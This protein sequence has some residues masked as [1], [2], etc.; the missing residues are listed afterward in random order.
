MLSP[1]PCAHCRLCP[2]LVP[3]ATAP[4]EDFPDLELGGEAFEGGAED[5]WRPAAGSLDELDEDDDGPAATWVTFEQ[6]QAAL[7]ALEAAE[8]G[9]PGSG[10]YASD[11]EEGEG[12]AA[13]VAGKRLPAEV[14]CFDTAR[15]YVKGGD[16][17]RGCVAFRREKYVPKGGPSGGNG[18]HGGSVYL[19]VDPSL[20]SLMAFRR[21]VHFRCA[22]C[23]GCRRGQARAEGELTP[24]PRA[25]GASAASARPTPAHRRA[26]PGVPGQ[27]SDMHG[28][29]GKDLL[30]KVPPGTIVRA[31]G[32]AEGDPPLYELLRPGARVRVASGGRGGRGNLAFKSARNNAPALAEFGE[33]VRQ[34]RGGTRTRCLPGARA[35]VAAALLPAHACSIH[36]IPACRAHTAG[37]RGVD[38]P[39]AEAGGRC[40]H[41]RLPQRRQEH[42][43]QV[44]CAGGPA[45]LLLEGLAPHRLLA[46]ASC[47]LPPAISPCNTPSGHHPLQRGVCRQAQDCQLPLH[48]A[49]PQPGRVQPGLPHHRVCRRAGAAGGR[50]RGRGAGP[51]VPAALPALPRAGAR[52]RRHQPRPHGRLP[53]HPP[54]ARPVQPAAGRQAAGA[55]LVRRRGG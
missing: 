24:Q 45:V 19:E 42:A 12:G 55:V 10:A 38:R 44:R 48:H 13:R 50:A 5:E 46:G 4:P 52:G 21:Q 32:A 27:G 26:E 7:A 3:Q 37:R 49:G 17:G 22:S 54:G 41:H 1:L 31:R 29:A 35:H 34:L 16:G 28:A 30:V 14:R 20:N 53:R 6:E 11:D 33:K 25:A 51:P 18:G 8:Q 43:A 47:A 9:G 2:A 23:V 36:T 15:I 39:G 40:G